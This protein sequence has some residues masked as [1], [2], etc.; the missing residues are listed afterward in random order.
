MSII[1]AIFF[2][3]FSKNGIPAGPAEREAVVY[4]NCFG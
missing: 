3:I 4:V 1:F 2:T